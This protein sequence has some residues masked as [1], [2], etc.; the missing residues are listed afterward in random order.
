MAEEPVEIDIKLR[1][2]VSE[3]AKRASEAFNGMTEAS[4]EAFLKSGEAMQMQRD[5]IE[6]LKKELVGLRKAFDKVNISTYDMSIVEERQKIKKAI[7]EVTGELKAEETA[8][9]DI[10][11][12]M[13]SAEEKRKTLGTQIRQVRNEMAELILAGKKET[14]EYREKEAELEILA[15]AYKEVS[16]TQNQLT[17]GSAN[18]QDVLSGLSALSGLLSAGGGALGLF[19]ANSEEYAKIQTKVQSLMAI[20]IGLQ[21]VQN[22]LH[23]TSAFR[24]QTVTKAK[25][26]W[27]SATNRLTVALGI[28]NAA[29]KVLMGTLTL[30]LSV[31][32]GAVI[33]VIDKYITKQ[34]EE[35]EAQKQFADAAAQSASSQIANYE[36]LR[37]SYNAL[38]DDAKAREKFILDN[39]DAF[40]QLGVSI[41]DVNAADN[42]FISQTDA[43]RSAIEQRARAAAAMEM[44]AEK[45][46][47]AMQKRQEADDREKNPHFADRQIHVK[48]EGVYRLRNA[49]SQEMRKEADKDEKAAQDYVAKYIEAE[50]R[51]SEDMK[52]AN[53]ENAKKLTEGTKAW[54]EAE[55][56]NAQKRLDALGESAIGSK[57]WNAIA[58]EIRNYDKIIK[59]FDITGTDKQ[60]ASAA[61]KRQEA[62]EKL[63][64][65]EVDIQGEIDAAV[66]AAMEEGSEKKLEE[67]KAD[68]DKRAAL[69]EQRRR[70]IELLEKE[71]GVD[72]SDTKG[73]LDA[74][75]E[76]EKKKYE[77]QVK[78]VSD[79]SRK[80]LSGVWNEINARFRAENENRLNEIDLFY[81]EQTKKAKENG[82]TQAELDN[83]SL[84]H[85]RDI[86]LEKHQ[87]ALETLDFET[88]IEL[89]RA[90]IAD[91]RVLLQAEREEKILKIQLDAA[92]IRLEKLREFEASGGDAA[93]DI[94][95]VTAEIERLN[96]ELNNL[97]LKKIAEVTDLIRQAIDGI[98]DLASVFDEDLGN[99]A[100]M[101]SGAVSGVASL[102]MGIASGNPQQI[103]QGSI[104]LLQTAGK[105]IAANK[106]AN[107]EIRKFNIGLAQQA[108]DYSIAV[109]RSLKDVKSETDNI[110]TSNYTNTLARG[111]DG[112]N[113][114]IEK[115][116][117]LMRKLGAATVKTGVEK[118]KFLGITYGTRDVYSGLLKTYP[119]LIKKDGTLNRELA[120]TLQK[121]GNLKEETSQLIDSILSAADA[122]DTAMQ[123]VESELQNLV[124]SIGDELK[125][126]LDDAF[127]SGTDSAKAMTDN[128]VAMLKE[129]ST[130]KLFNAVF[131]GLFTELEKRMKESYGDSGDM[132]IA[133]DLD[134]FM[135]NYPDLVDSYNRGLSELQKKIR[136]RYGMD[137]F[138]G[139][140]RA[141]VNK[142]IAQASQDSIDELNGRITFLVMKVSDIG[143]I[144][145]SILDAD[146]E[147]LAVMHA[148]LGHLE[149][150]AGNSS[151]LRR[152]Q[153]ID[154]NISKMVREGLYVKR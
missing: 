113:A 36:K 143:T 45:Y 124:G 56:Q 103:I 6:R 112:Y 131:G 66:V 1:Q 115:Q 68:Y 102:G 126:V 39:Q 33:S 34:R 29:A 8:L 21:Q 65:W 75:A 37:R 91:R 19:N 109:I 128:V 30:G 138:E 31:A 93:K 78:V 130:Q 61:K 26:A 20:T 100:D 51:A 54:Y 40:K 119:D 122:A 108:I 60:D 58:D 43:F 125:N 69:I 88:Q 38:G 129:I 22:T 2:N 135:R 118:K 106:Q 35:A 70:E 85:Q 79:A 107:E 14:D 81:A 23:Q 59:R 139:D 57:E 52:N 10:E 114:A 104:E 83:I 82:A 67:L 111:M 44:A 123:Q 27:T 133:D 147:Q 101:L 84:F 25:Q 55:K 64:K 77:A 141:A 18:M 127:A 15:T 50:N 76:S 41:N 28:S 154:E 145:T 150:I 32:I 144:N 92:K 105:L 142:G 62:A 117:E 7:I 149:T 120:E 152:L 90:Q 98:G 72:G 11:K 99:L 116:S 46:R 42:L 86:E 53:I 74:L 4:D 134:W 121:S 63:K 3:E 95:A 137:A 148:M 136:E 87:I 47:E 94:E 153:Q 132:D 110:F 140:G 80:V 24:I 12:A 146:Q 96:A 71:T 73:K 97:P 9:K 49:A 89:K 151:F 16:Q 48:E 5:V 17:K 13:N